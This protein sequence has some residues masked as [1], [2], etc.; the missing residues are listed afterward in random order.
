MEEQ[1]QRTGEVRAIEELVASVCNVELKLIFFVFLHIKNKMLLET[2]LYSPV[3]CLVSFCL[4]V[5][6]CICRRTTHNVPVETIRRML[7]GYERYV[8]VQSI[9]GSQM[10]EIKQRL[11]LE[12]RSSQ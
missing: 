3:L 5:S 8:T 11:L 1:A 2:I 12:N 7:N 6:I 10:P 9:M 4:C